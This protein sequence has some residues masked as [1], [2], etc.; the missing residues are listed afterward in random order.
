MTYVFVFAVVSLNKKYHTLFHKWD[1][2]I[3]TAGGNDPDDVLL[4]FNTSS[5]PGMQQVARKRVLAL[6]REVKKGGS[7]NVV[8]EMLVTLH[9]LQARQM[10]FQD[11]ED[12][13]EHFADTLFKP[14]A[15]Q[16]RKVLKMSN[17]ELQIDESG[18]QALIAEMK[19]FIDIAE[20]AFDGD[21]EV[22][23]PKECK[24]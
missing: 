11:T 3:C 10:F 15:L 5:S 14:L 18:R 2:D 24:K 12:D 21:L 16:M 8:V 23:W 7:I 1:N 9:V 13:A 6:G 19:E 20:S 22:N 4:L 17:E